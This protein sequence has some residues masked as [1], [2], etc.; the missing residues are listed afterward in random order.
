MRARLSASVTQNGVG[1]TRRSSAIF[2]T[3]PISAN[4]WPL[5]SGAY[6]APRVCTVSLGGSAIFR[7]A[8]C[9]LFELNCNLYVKH[10]LDYL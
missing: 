10:Y 6:D 8:L 1:L 7:Q 9:R 3:S 2:V 4:F 5:V